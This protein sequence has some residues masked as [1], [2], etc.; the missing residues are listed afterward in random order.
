MNL[1]FRRFQ[2][3]DYPEYAAWFIDPELNRRLGPMDQEWLDAVLT[4]PE[5]A[6][7]T[8][9]VLRDAELVAVV[10][11]VFDHQNHKPAGITAMAAKPSLRRQ[12][13]GTAVLRQILSQH[14]SRGIAE[15]VAYIAIDNLAG[16]RCIERV[17]FVPVSTEPNEHGF[18]EYRHRQPAAR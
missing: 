11:T 3:E 13:I 8:W 7:I 18:I 2:Q 15:H 9:A 1:V 4:E 5:S 14:Q 16:Q 10:E 6:G 17:G 12:G